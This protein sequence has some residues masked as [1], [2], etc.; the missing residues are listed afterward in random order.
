MLSKVLS[1]SDA[2][3][4]R[5]A[6]FLSAPAP[7]PRPEAARTAY[8]GEIRAL[9]AEIARLE[10]EIEIVRVDSFES[11][12]RQGEEIARSEISKVMERMNASVADLVGMRQE[13]RRSAERDVVQLALLMAQRVLHRELSVD[14]GA[15]TALARV[16][17][18]RMASAESYRV[19]VNPRF[20]ESIRSAL[21]GRS[22][23]KVRIEAD[24]NCAQGTFLV[25]S[26]DGTVD[27]SIDRQLEEIGRGLVDRL[28]GV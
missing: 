24:A 2:E 26:E 13:L 9:R 12:K 8:D 19:T 22:E 10:A 23:S 11:G 27:A 7:I 25:R 3:R 6:N 14:P 4:A 1:G 21:P 20:A 5:P 15:L 16:V 18:E 28:A 17:F